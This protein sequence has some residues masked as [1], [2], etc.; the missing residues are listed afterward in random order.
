MKQLREIISERIH[1]EHT[2]ADNDVDITVDC[3]GLNKEMDENER[4]ASIEEFTERLLTGGDHFL[5]AM[6]FLRK[7]VL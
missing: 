7:S 1:R 2:D 4:K 5:L 6:R 3:L